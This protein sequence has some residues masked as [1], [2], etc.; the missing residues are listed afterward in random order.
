[1]NKPHQIT[2]IDDPSLRPLSSRVIGL[3]R[4]GNMAVLE[5]ALGHISLI[6]IAFISSVERD[7]LV[8]YVKAKIKRGI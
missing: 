4:D 2:V 7:C 8:E 1:M 6:S 3:T 5:N